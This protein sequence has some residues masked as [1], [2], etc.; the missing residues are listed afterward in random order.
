MPS[1]IQMALFTGILG[2][3]QANINPDMLRRSDENYLKSQKYKQGA[4]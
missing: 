1:E 3:P 2:L 4:R